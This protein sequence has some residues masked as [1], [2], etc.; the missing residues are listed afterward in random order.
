MWT[1][2]ARFGGS[3]YIFHDLWFCVPAS[4]PVVAGLLGAAHEVKLI[5][6]EFMWNQQVFAI[7][8][9]VVH[10]IVPKS[11]FHFF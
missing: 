7:L 3:G 11:F 9:F 10:Q 1:Y 6:E 5:V 4:R 8:R 2:A